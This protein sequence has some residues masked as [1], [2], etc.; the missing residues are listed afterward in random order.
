MPR[1]RN[2][3]LDRAML[4]LPLAFAASTIGGYPLWNA[5]PVDPMSLAG[6]PSDGSCTFSDPTMRPSS[7]TS[8]VTSR[9]S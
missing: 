3:P 1:L 7:S 5:L 8:T 4:F 6:D 9:P 2:M